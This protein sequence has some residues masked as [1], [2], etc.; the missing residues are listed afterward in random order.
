M[1]IK[2]KIFR[3]LHIVDDGKCD[4]CHKDL[5]EN[6]PTHALFDGKELVAILCD[7]CNKELNRLKE[8]RELD[9]SKR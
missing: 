3:F 8:Q 2:R 1:S 6:T 4:E 9:I 5:P 7:E